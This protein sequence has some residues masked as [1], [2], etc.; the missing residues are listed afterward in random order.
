MI[1]D[2]QRIARMAEELISDFLRYGCTDMDLKIL[3]RE[4][5]YIISISA[6][7]KGVKG[8]EVEKIRK[9]LNQ[10]RNPQMEEYFWSLSGDSDL[11]TEF[12]LLGIMSDE[13]E[14]KYDEKSSRLSIKLTRGK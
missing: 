14:L 3:E 2:K 12:S 5:L 7:C 1:H 11:D 10:P 6:Y 9:L 4:D 8:R 13:V